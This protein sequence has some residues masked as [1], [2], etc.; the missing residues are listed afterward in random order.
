MNEITILYIL[1][2]IWVAPWLM[3]LIYM[4]IKF[5]KLKR[6]IEMFIEENIEDEKPRNKD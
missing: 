5:K 4:M 1:V 2:V 3:A 6:R